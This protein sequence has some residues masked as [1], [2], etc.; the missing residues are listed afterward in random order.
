M[1]LKQIIIRQVVLTVDKDVDITNLFEDTKIIYGRKH[2]DP[3]IIKS[4]AKQYGL[5]VSAVERNMENFK[6]YVDSAD[7]VRYG[8]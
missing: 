5:G 4:Y 7:I 2:Q 6:Q 3:N 8:K 1:T